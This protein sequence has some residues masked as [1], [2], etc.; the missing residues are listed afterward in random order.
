MKTLIV[1]GSIYGYSE[2]CARKLKNLLG[3]ETVLVNA[4]KDPIPSLELFDGVVIG[5][6][7]YM[8]QIQKQIKKFIKEH[9]KELLQKRVC[10]YMCCA[11]VDNF[12]VELENSFPDELI[13][14]AVDIESFGGRLC[15]DKM[16]FM[17]RTMTKMMMKVAA[18]EGKPPVSEFPQHIEK[19]A[20]AMMNSA[21]E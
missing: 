2:E 8:G 15:I 16:S 1:Y 11:L 3:E 9:L 10:L 5:G 20:Q 13:Q 17:H 12:S 7:I 6:S 4:L 21:K 19:L 14:S 18:K